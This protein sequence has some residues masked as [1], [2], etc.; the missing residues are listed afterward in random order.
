MPLEHISIAIEETQQFRE[1]VMRGEVDT[2]GLR[3][4]FCEL[5]GALWGMQ[6]TDLIIL[7]ARSGAGKTAK[8]INIINN[9]IC[10]EKENCLFFSLE[11]S[12]KQIVKR[13]VCYKTKIPNNELKDIKNLTQTH[14]TKIRQA[15][16]EISK[17][18]LFIDD[19]TNN[20]TE[21]MYKEAKAHKREHGLGLIVV[22]YLQFVKPRISSGKRNIDVGS[23]VREL[24]VMA[25]DLE[26]PVLV[27]SQL[28]RGLDKDDR[29]PVMSDLRESGDIEQNADVILFLHPTSKS[30][31]PVI[32]MELIIGKNRDGARKTIKTTFEGATFSFKEEKIPPITKKAV[33]QKFT[34]GQLIPLD[35]GEVENI[36]QE[37]KSEH[38]QNIYNREFT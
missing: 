5:D 18:K 30:F 3:T 17:T 22:D 29:R 12:K 16:S 19:T 4:G 13:L 31:E 34:A 38:K 27:L 23:I 15:E 6:K 33:Q 20:T 8:A 26:V 36:F 1:K 37:K 11:M 24:K 32:N 2:F 10:S 28:D 9:V 7:A 21:I 14:L 25:K 35:E